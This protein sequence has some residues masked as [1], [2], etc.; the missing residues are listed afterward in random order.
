MPTKKQAAAKKAAPA[1][2]AASKKATSKKAAAKTRKPAIDDEVTVS[3]QHA[4]ENIQQPSEPPV[5]DE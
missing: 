3:L 1:K 5:F 2:K 4:V